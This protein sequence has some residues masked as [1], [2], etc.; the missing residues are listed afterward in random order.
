MEYLSTY[1]VHPVLPDVYMSVVG[2]DSVSFFIHLVICR[3]LSTPTVCV[4]FWGVDAYSI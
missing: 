2:L 4:N 3:S 1:M